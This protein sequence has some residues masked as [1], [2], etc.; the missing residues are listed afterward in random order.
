MAQGQ[1]TQPHEQSAL[2][3]QRETR[4]IALPLE[5]RKV[6]DDV[7]LDGLG[8]VYYNAAKPEETQYRLWTNVWE[9]MMP[10]VF[11]KALSRPDDVRCLFNHNVDVVLGR[12]VS[13]T[14][15]LKTDPAGLRFSTKL[16]NDIDGQRVAEKIRRGDVS[17]CSISFIADEVVWREEGDNTYREI[18]SVRL[19]DVGPVTFPAYTGTDV[20]LA[21]RCHGEFLAQKG[22]GTLATRERNLRLKAALQ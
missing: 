18:L 16:P 22:H 19:Y 8:A 1:M 15:T 5:L 9:R 12:S 13:Q 3:G 14:L 6:G 11:D 21:K 4:V 7:F 17:G 20:T 10:G 2:A